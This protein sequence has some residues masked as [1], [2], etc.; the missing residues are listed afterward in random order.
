MLTK[1]GCAVVSLNAVPGASRLDGPCDSAH[2]QSS[3]AR[4]ADPTPVIIATSLEANPEDQNTLRA[5]LPSPFDEVV[6]GTSGSVPSSVPVRRSIGAATN[7]Q[8]SSFDEAPVDET[9]LIAPD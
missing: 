7:A 6:A 1:A 8:D 3:V 2:E 4:R 5:S 9:V